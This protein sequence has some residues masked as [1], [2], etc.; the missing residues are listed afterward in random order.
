MSNY[1][2]LFYDKTTNEVIANQ[3]STNR[4]DYQTSIDIGLNAGLDSPGERSVAIGYDAG[5]IDQG[6]EAIAIGFQAGIEQQFMNSII[7]NASGEPVNSI[8]SGF[9]VSPV[10]WGNTG[11]QM[12]LYDENTN[13][14]QYTNITTFVGSQGSQGDGFI[15]TQGFQGLGFVG[16]QGFQGVENLGTQGLQGIRGDAGGFTR[17]INILDNVES[18][19]SL[20]GIVPAWT[21]N[22][23]TFGGVVMFQGSLVAAPQSSAGVYSVDML[24]DGVVAATTTLY[25]YSNIR[26]TFPCYF[27][28]ENLTAGT[29]LFQLRLSGGLQVNI[30]RATV[31]FI[32]VIGGNSV[33]LVGP[34]GA[35]GIGFQGVQG[36]MGTQ[37]RQGFQGIVGFG[38]QGLQGNQGLVGTQGIQGIAGEFAGQGVQGVQGIAAT[39]GGFIQMVQILD[40]VAATVQ[41]GP[42]IVTN[43]TSSFTSYGGRIMFEGSLTA[44]SSAVVLCV[45]EILV[46]SIVIGSVSYFFNQTFTK[47][48]IPAYFQVE[49]IAAGTHTISIRIPANARVDTNDF[50]N[51]SFIEVVGANTIGIQGPIGIGIQGNQGIIGSQGVQ[52]LQGL[53][54]GIGLQGIV[55]EIGLQ[56][57]QGIAG[58][59]LQGLQGLQGLDGINGL[60]GFQGN[61]LQ[62]NVGDIGLQGL[63]GKIGDIGLQGMMGIGLQPLYLQ[64]INVATNLPIGTTNVSF[65]YRI[66]YSPW[67]SG[68]YVK[69][70]DETIGSTLSY[71]GQL[72]FIFAGGF[73]WALGLEEILNVFGTPNGDPSQTWRM[74]LSTIPAGT[75]GLQG[76]DGIDG[77]Q[78]LQ[79]MLG[80]DGLQG[81][82]G[83]DGLQGNIGLQG[84]QGLQGFRG[85]QGLNGFIGSTGYF[86]NV[87][88]TTTQPITITP[89]PVSFNTIDNNSGFSLNGGGTQLIALQ[90]GLYNIQFSFQFVNTD[91]IIQ[92]IDVFFRKN[93]VVIPNSNSVFS[94]PARHGGITDGLIIASMN[95][96]LD[97][98]AND[99]FEIL[100]SSSIDGQITIQ[101][102][103]ATASVP[104]TP[105]KILT[106]TPVSNLLQGNQGLQGLQGFQG[107]IGLQGTQMPQLTTKSFY[108]NSSFLGTTGQGDS[109]VSA[110]TG[111][112]T[113][114]PGYTF[115]LSTGA[116]T[117]DATINNLLI[118]NYYFVGVPNGPDVAPSCATN[119]FANVYIGGNATNTRGHFSNIQFANNVGITGQ[120]LNRHYFNSCTFEKGFIFSSTNNA[121]WI[122]FNNCE[123]SAALTI[124]NTSTQIIFQDC[125]FGGFAITNQ[126]VISPFLTIFNNCSGLPSF[127]LGSCTFGGQNSTSAGS[128]RTDSS[129]YYQNGVLVNPF[130]QQGAQGRQGS[131][132]FQG[133]QGTSNG[134]TKISGYVNSQVPLTLN[135]MKIQYNTAIS[136][137]TLEIAT[138]TGTFDILGNGIYNNSG[139]S[140]GFIPANI[141]TITT[142]F[143]SINNIVAIDNPESLLIWYLTDTTN[144][145]SYQVLL[146]TATAL[147]NNFLLLQQLN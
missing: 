107:R 8:N 49:N 92:D 44:F 112:S 70:Y 117:A 22:F 114:I 83:I 91:T 95:Y 50:A 57:F 2:P 5:M 26:M 32:E 100:T 142:T 102:F 27:N 144:S 3:S 16:T 89:T 132:G 97:M 28:V 46:D 71:Y 63:Q 133:V 7:L 129:Q 146:Q 12:L 15:G 55:G 17:L 43:W 137:I 67:W 98:N 119:I 116:H 51:L 60:Q 42:I 94:V 82:L 73:G 31:S 4:Y 36:I 105:S 93:N 56:G 109:I 47:Q 115:Y 61:G 75:Q 45:F 52:G 122:Y 128:T 125:K 141:T 29:H 41:N 121:N 90:K 54:G 39:N 123:F 21:R 18:P 80:I 6:E 139:V 13:E 101:T 33:G 48:S 85:F 65:G 58:Y 68:A 120:S 23:T 25:F 38:L 134:V 104:Q 88:D 138:T 140:Q 14:I 87:S 143:Q 84:F 74:E 113:G 30:D 77:L 19:F 126:Q 59:G 24:I 118:Q 145:R 124:P 20:G 37:G 127:S 136:P 81:M 99:Y 130:G 86:F 131:I 9:F 78:G 147:S 135:N 11:T 72:Q 64:G 96:L 1:L 40:N 76:L 53:V 10:R 66:D 79:G 111:L 69:F 106:I 35:I 110:L 34:Q 103:P 62:G 108:I